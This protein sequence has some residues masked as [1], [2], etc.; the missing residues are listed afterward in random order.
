MSL[1]PV[2]HF[3]LI[4]VRRL[5]FCLVFRVPIRHLGLI[6]VRRLAFCLVF[7]LCASDS[8]SGFGA[9]PWIGT[10]CGASDSVSDFG[11]AP[12]ILS[13]VSVSRLG[14]PLGFQSSTL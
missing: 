11:L 6:L 2:R 5:G 9:A 13:R 4:L 8:V 7:R 14:F 3:G 12:Q 1:V 10:G